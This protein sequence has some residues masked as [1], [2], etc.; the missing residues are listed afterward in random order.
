[1]GYSPEGCKESDTTEQLTFH[2]AA[3]ILASDS[4]RSCGSFPVTVT[5]LGAC[6]HVCVWAC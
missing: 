6:M 3:L 4:S 5:A 2:F 1:M